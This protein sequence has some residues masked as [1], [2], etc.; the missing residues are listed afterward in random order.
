MLQMI[1]IDGSYGEGGGQI[2]RTSLSLSCLFGK[3][4]RIFDIRKARKKPG[5]MPQHLTAVRA[6]QMLS[7][8]KVSGDRHGSTE[9][10]FSPGKIRGGH[11]SFDIGTAGSIA[12]VLQTLFPALIFSGQKSRLIISG[13]THVPF[14]P[15]IDYLRNIFALTLKKMGITL[16]LAIE[17]YGFYPR[18]GGK[19]RAEIFPSTTVNPVKVSERGKV[20]RLKGYSGVGNLPLSIAERQRNTFVEK[21]HEVLGKTFPIDIEVVDAPTPGQGTFLFAAAESEHCIA[22]FASLGE[23]GKKA[24]VVGA[25]AAA[26]LLDYFESGAA[27]DHHLADQIALYLALAKGESSFT[28]SK[29]TSHL[30]TNLW[31]ISLFHEFGYS[32][33]GKT[34]EPGRVTVQGNPV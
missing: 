24:E 20:I 3:P 22:G 1:E 18:G 34:G 5:L 21:V 26:E 32:V 25:E 15:S 14:S 12:L 10:I 19:V 17:S 13:G 8:A 27:L 11:F 2:L 33:G 4:F 31:A 30:L 29:I 23:R 7:G 6:A 9:L 16:N 28:T